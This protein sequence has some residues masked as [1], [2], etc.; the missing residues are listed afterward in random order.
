[1]TDEKE[2]NSGPLNEKK[3]KRGPIII[4]ELLFSC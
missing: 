3:K 4:P 1:M 2:C